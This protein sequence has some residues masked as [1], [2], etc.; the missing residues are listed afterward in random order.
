MVCSSP[1]ATPC[2][3]GMTWFCSRPGAPR[4]RAASRRARVHGGCLP[5]A[6]HCPGRLWRSQVSMLSVRRRGSRAHSPLRHRTDPHGRRPRTKHAVRA[7]RDGRLMDTSPTP[8]PFL[9]VIE[10]AAS[11]AEERDE[12][13][14]TQNRCGS[15]L[16]GG[17]SCISVWVTRTWCGTRLRPKHGDPHPVHATLTKDEACTEGKDAGD[18]T[19]PHSFRMERSRAV[20]LRRVLEGQQLRPAPGQVP[21]SGVA[22]GDPCGVG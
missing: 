6:G 14:A 21:W 2:Y 19:I 18:G 13:R 9:S 22:V 4:H 7:H 11:R 1:G 20:R 3:R 16:I 17:G 8:V 10:T 5:G 15:F 12:M